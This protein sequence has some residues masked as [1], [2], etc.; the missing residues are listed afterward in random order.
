LRSL[1]PDA[2]HSGLVLKLWTHRFTDRHAFLLFLAAVPKNSGNQCVSR[3]LIFVLWAVWTYT[4][5]GVLS[6]P[7]SPPFTAQTPLS[8]SD[9]LSKFGFVRSYRQ[10]SEIKETTVLRPSFL[11]KSMPLLLQNFLIGFAYCGNIESRFFLVAGIKR[12]NLSPK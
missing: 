10:E 6:R 7:V 8:W 3:C 12:L 9:P 4:I 11:L 1:F 2:S 5:C